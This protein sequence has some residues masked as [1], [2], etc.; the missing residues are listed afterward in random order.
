MSLESLVNCTLVLM[1]G[2]L[3]KIISEEAAMSD[4]EMLTLNRTA[5]FKS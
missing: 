2:K 1:L 3:E 5:G 4:V